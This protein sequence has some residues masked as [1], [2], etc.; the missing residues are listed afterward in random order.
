MR[1][2]LGGIHEMSNDWQ[3]TL[4]FA[5]ACVLS[6]FVLLAC[7]PADRTAGKKERDRVVTTLDKMYANYLSGSIVDARSNLVKAIAFIHENGR[8]IPELEIALPICYARLSLL[9]R[10][11]GHDELSRIYYEKSRYWR[12]IIHEKSQLKPQEIVA[13]YDAVT[14][15][16][17]DKYALEWDK[18]YTDGVGPAYL[19]RFQ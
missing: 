13:N 7:T 8:D 12:I 19:K 1:R 4:Q 2:V 14:R 11:A 9:E 16:E 15:D 5:A 10:K 17:S 18:K 6:S 3:K